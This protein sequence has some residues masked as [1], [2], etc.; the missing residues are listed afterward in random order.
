M[1][2]LSEAIANLP[3]DAAEELAEYNPIAIDYESLSAEDLIG[4]DLFMQLCSMPDALDRAQAESKCLER[5]K[6]LKQTQAYQRCYKAYKQRASVCSNPTKGNSTDFPNTDIVL[7]CGRYVCDADGVRIMR[8]SES[9]S[10]VPEMVSP[11]PIMPVEIITN[12]GTNTEKVKLMFYKAKRWDSVISERSVVSSSN[13]ILDLANRGVEVNSE[14]SKE[15]VKYIFELI[16]LN[17]DNI[18]RFEASTRMG[19]TDGDFKAFM[20]YTDAAR[21]DGD[22]EYKSLYNGICGQGD[23]GTWTMLTRELRNNLYMRLTIDAS[24]ASPLIQMVDGLPFV[25]HLWG[26]TEAGKTV[27][28]KVAASVWGNPE[29]SMMHS[30]NATKNAMLG[31]AGFLNNIPFIADE[32][33]VIKSRRDWDGNYDNLVMVL[34][35]GKNRERM[36][37][38]A[39]LKETSSWQCGFIFSGED[40]CTKQDSG[41][42]VKNRVVEIFCDR[43]VVDDGNAV[44]GYIAKHHG[45]AG[46]IYTDILSEIG[47]DKINSL[48]RSYWQKLRSSGTTDKQAQAMAILL[49][50]DTIAAKRI[51]GDE[52]P[53]DVDDVAALLKTKSE[54][55]VSERAYAYIINRIAVSNNNFSNEA[56]EIWGTINRVEN[57]ALINKDILVREL[58]ASGFDFESV[59][60]KWMDNHYLIPNSQGRYFHNTSCG[61]IKATYIKL[62]T[63][64]PNQPE[65]Q[66]EPFT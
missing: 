18:P 42:G 62:S 13:K 43:A 56:R 44:V 45:F 5:A 27:A 6:K 25:F 10:M 61:G 57:T 22:S 17:A 1:S 39:K 37:S 8:P 4:E 40:P 46:K 29:G 33:Q 50:A 51:Y 7:N 41:G 58:G 26:G 23:F 14:T 19:W 54:V 12:A 65:T 49:V 52:K 60:K 64:H 15:L 35:E 36:G 30:L 48:Y 47:A 9:G 53:L 24:L 11:I 32:L 38:D 34:C 55:D 59:K 16:N 21:F 28:L 20:P 66:S 3:D 2:K 63:E 31:A